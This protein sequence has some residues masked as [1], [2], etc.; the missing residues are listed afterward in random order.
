LCSGYRHYAATE[1][2]PPSQPPVKRVVN[3]EG[4]TLGLDLAG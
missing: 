2:L 3:W 4:I 1:F